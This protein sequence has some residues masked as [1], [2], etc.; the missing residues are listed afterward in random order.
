MNLPFLSRPPRVAVVRLHGAIMASSG[1]A[2]GNVLNIAS[3]APVLER[4]FSLKRASAVCL[5]INSPGGSPVQSSLI[6]QR[7]RALAEEKHLP[8]L[9]FVEDAAA[10]GGYWLAC[11]ADEIFADPAS[12]VGSI[13]VI[14]QG[15]GL[16]GALAR[17]GVERRL[18]TAGTEKSFWDPF[19]PERPADVARLDA[20]L[21]ELHAEFTG[22]VSAR[23]GARLR[24]PAGEVVTGRVWGGRR[25]VELGLADGLGEVRGEM[26]R[27]FGPKVKLVPFGGRRR[28]L[29]SRLLPGL[30]AEA[31]LEVA[32]ERA[33]WGRLGL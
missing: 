2:G 33:L 8:V 27:R 14:A 24:A 13:G 20:L 19:A 9:A 1:L 18:R 6:A 16:D 11:A 10:S 21:A 17:L 26:R 15:F 12:I 25:A 31:L 7:I 30:S 5:V 4:A 22:W 3:L 23:R 29:L 32:A 28:G